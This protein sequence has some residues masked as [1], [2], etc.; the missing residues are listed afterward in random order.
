MTDI[1]FNHKNF[2]SKVN[3]NIHYATP[4][5]LSNGS[6]ISKVTYNEDDQKMNISFKT[7]RF[8]LP[9]GIQKSQD[10]SLFIDLKRD[11]TNKAFYEF[12]GELDEIGMGVVV[13]KSK[14]WFGFQ[15]NP[16]KIDKQYHNLLRTGKKSE[17][18]VRL[19][20]DTDALVVNNQY[21]KHLDL[22]SICSDSN[23]AVKIRYEGLSFYEKEIEPVYRVY[24]IKH[25]QTRTTGDEK[26]GESDNETPN[27]EVNNLEE[28]SESVEEINEGDNV[29]EVSVQNEVE[30]SVEENEV[31][32]NGLEEDLGEFL[33][34][35][36]NVGEI[37][38][39]TPSESEIPVKNLTKTEELSVTNLPMDEPTAA[40]LDDDN[41]TVESLRRKLKIQREKY[42]K[43]KGV[44]SV[45]TSFTENSRK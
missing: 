29:E 4:R 31:L 40:L 35:K 1:V 5:K 32:E 26:F 39:N 43:V 41:D 17:I 20:L 14:K 11:D 19:P 12:M 9:H 10:G 44:R 34:E 7:Q 18:Y 24:E 16:N 30:V 3:S 13:D 28:D 36:E 25:Y 45:E 27:F 23:V 42:I 37:E 21:G 33:K 22:D 15:V 8:N 38:T 6:L 2:E